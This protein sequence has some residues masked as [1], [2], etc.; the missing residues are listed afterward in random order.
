LC[1]PPHGKPDR[2][3]EYSLQID[4]AQR[5]VWRRENRV[6]PVGRRG[7]VPIRVYPSKSASR[8]KPNHCSRS[9]LSAIDARAVSLQNQVR[10]SVELLHRSLPE[11]GALCRQ[12]EGTV[13]DAAEVCDV[14]LCRLADD[15]RAL[16]EDRRPMSVGAA[17]L[18]IGPRLALARL[19]SNEH[20]K[21]CSV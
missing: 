3:P 7:G 6:F 19:P 17:S 2:R 8:C 21:P 20:G 5:H 18:T 9:F 4:G 12:F 15:S 10:Q 1:E 14:F 13:I 16:G 11:K